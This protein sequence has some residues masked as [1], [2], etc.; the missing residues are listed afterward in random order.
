[1]MAAKGRDIEP[2][3][4]RG[5]DDDMAAKFKDPDDPF[6]LVFL[7]AMWLTGFDAPSCSTIYLDKPMK[8]HALMQTIARANRVCG[9][10]EAGLIVDYV[11]VFRNLQRALA[12][13]AR[14]TASGELPIK[15]KA[16]LLAEVQKALNAVLAFAPGR[17]VRP[18]AIMATEWSSRLLH[19]A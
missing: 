13:Y 6:R 19:P 18:E 3:R 15:D 2:H 11:G 10:K 1:D 7:C 17:G 5:N 16:A 12:I 9:D 4:R 14:G 8:N